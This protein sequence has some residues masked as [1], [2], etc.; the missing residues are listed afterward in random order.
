MP[1]LVV[2]VGLPY[3]GKT[4]LAARLAGLGWLTISQVIRMAVPKCTP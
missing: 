1:R 2:L 4:T 3:S